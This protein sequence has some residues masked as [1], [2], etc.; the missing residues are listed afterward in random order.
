MTQNF[1]SR[2]I[3]FQLLRNYRKHSGWIHFQPEKIGFS[4]KICNC[5]NLPAP[6]AIDRIHLWWIRSLEPSFRARRGRFAIWWGGSASLLCFMHVTRRWRQTQSLCSY[7]WR[8]HSE[9]LLVWFSLVGWNKGAGISIFGPSRLKHAAELRWRAL[10]D[11]GGL[12]SW[13]LAHV[14]PSASI[15]LL[16]DLQLKYS[17]TPFIVSI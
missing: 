6:K 11:C 3:H 15:P 4:L 5:E 7:V 16:S 12:S 2:R 9:P 17:F 8:Q 14:L 1:W 13:C 10:G